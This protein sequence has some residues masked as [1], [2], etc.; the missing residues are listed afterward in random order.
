MQSKLIFLATLALIP[1]LG[2]CTKPDSGGGQSN[3]V[4]KQIESMDLDQKAA[5]AAAAIDESSADQALED[6]ERELSGE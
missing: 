3:D 2:A 5:D 1:T 4:M 6:M